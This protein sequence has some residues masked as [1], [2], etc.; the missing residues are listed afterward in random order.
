MT[1]SFRSGDNTPDKGWTNVVEHDI[2]PFPADFTNLHPLV[3]HMN[4]VRLP[5]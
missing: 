4:M 1:L 3:H 5:T 2:P